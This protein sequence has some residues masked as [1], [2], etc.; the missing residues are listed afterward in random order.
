MFCTTCGNKIEATEKFCT[1]CG[2]SVSGGKIEVSAA[3]PEHQNFFAL[4][5]RVI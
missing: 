5:G 3:N 2:N 1:K 4:L